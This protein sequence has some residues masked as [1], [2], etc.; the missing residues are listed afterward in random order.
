MTQP[1]REDRTVK[2]RFARTIILYSIGIA[3][4]IFVV[5]WNWYP[6]PDG[7]SPGIATLL[8]KEIHW[9]S[10]LIGAALFLPGLLLQFVR[11]HLLVRAQNLPFT[12]FNAIRLGLVGFFFNSILPG[13]VG[14]DLVKAIFIAKEQERK[15]V[16]VATVLIDRAIGLWGL[17]WLVLLSGGLFWLLGNE[18]I[19][20]EASLRSLIAMTGGFIAGT[21]ILWLVLGLLPE[22][23]AVK[24]AGR[25]GRIPRIGHSAAEFWRAVWIYRNKRRSIVYSLAL[26]IAAHCFF[27]AAFYFAARMFRDPGENI[28]I[29]SLAQHFLFVPICF[30]SEAFVF[31]PGGI[32]AGEFIFSW[33]YKLLGAPPANAVAASLA[34]RVIVWGWSFIG[35]IIYEQMKPA[36]AKVEVETAIDQESVGAVLDAAK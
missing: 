36:L 20:T 23:R 24:F 14:G 5:W 18:A 19:S 29:P 31:L 22:R 6:S 32:G 35:L 12:L 26:T 9:A 33:F 21:V 4:L 34:R 3:A 25:L 16:A 2:N 30:A 10:L 1:E 28:Q 13:S 15:T 8:S 17:I 7:R 11:W 27:V